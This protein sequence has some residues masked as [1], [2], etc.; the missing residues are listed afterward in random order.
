MMEVVGATVKL[1]L[2]AVGVKSDVQTAGNLMCV[3]TSMF[4]VV[5]G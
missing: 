2:Q 3:L 1:A 5:L 4:R